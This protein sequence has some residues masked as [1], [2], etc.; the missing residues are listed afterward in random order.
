MASGRQP[1]LLADLVAHKYPISEEV[2]GNFWDRLGQRELEQGEALAVV[3][4]A[5]DAARPTASR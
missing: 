1:Q 5:D 4:L 2:W 3:V